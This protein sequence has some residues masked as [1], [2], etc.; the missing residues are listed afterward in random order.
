MKNEIRQALWNL[1]NLFGEDVFT[2]HSK[3]KA[4]L[5]DVLPGSSNELVRN[6]LNNAIGSMNAYARLKKSP[7]ENM[8]VDVY[9]LIK[10]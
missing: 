7:S 2:A 6:L 3:F 4:G 5:S 8:G 9:N 1:K 10:K